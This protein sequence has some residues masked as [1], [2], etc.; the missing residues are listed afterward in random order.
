MNNVINS[1]Y[2]FKTECGWID[3]KKGDTCFIEYYTECKYRQ[4]FNGVC[5]GVSGLQKNRRVKLYNIKENIESIFFIN[6]P[7]IIQIKI[8]TAK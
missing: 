6:S 4:V 2:G 7:N 5:I 1:L 8:L 3:I